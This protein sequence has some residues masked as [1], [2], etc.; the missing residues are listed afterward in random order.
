MRVILFDLIPQNYLNIYF[1]DNDRFQ[2]LIEG[3]NK[4]FED[5]YIIVQIL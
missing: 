4:H 3:C 5:S 2:I 1:E